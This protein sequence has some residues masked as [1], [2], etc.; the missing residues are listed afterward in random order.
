M[1]EVTM[2]RI[3]QM[4]AMLVMLAS[5]TQPAAAQEGFRLGYTDVGATIGLGGIGSAAI[6]FGVRVE[7]ALRSMPNLGDGLL[8]I[9]AGADFYSW[10]APGERW[11][12][13]PIGATANYHF[14]LENK[15]L[16][17]FLGLGLGYSIISCS[18][19]GV[20]DLCS[21]SALYFIGRA[22]GRYFFNEKMSLYSD[23][24]AGAAMLNVGLT[25]RLK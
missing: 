6:A 20:V 24:G 2:S 19:S 23:V 8:G 10:S 22:G 11:S 13:I 5:L 4:A 3:F 17:P 7:H 9:Q 14:N 25:L 1:Q 18:Y 15:K 21:N 12:Y 16:D